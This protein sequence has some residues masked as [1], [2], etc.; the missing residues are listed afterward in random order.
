MNWAT[1]K[2]PQKST[3]SP[4]MTV[5]QTVCSEDMQ[6]PGIDWESAAM[7]KLKDLLPPLEKDE[8]DRESHPSQIFL[9]QKLVLLLTIATTIYWVLL[10]SGSI[11]CIHPTHIIQPNPYSDTPGRNYIPILQLRKFAHSF[12]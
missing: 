10:L 9:L 11:Y 8:V 3:D 12:K 4:T 7:Q 1:R 5:S 2:L 6:C